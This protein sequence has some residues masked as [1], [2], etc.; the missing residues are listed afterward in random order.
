MYG[1][2]YYTAYS[3]FFS[4]VW[5]QVSFWN[6]IKKIQ[7]NIKVVCIFIFGM[8]LK[9]E[10]KIYSKLVEI[11][12]WNITFKINNQCGISSTEIVNIIIKIKIYI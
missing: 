9:N 6:K 8:K 10:S 3:I 7:L 5:L 4:F 2:I 12:W 1:V 11:Y